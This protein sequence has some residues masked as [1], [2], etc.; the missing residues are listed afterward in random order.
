MTQNPATVVTLIID[1]VGIPTLEYLLDN[2]SG[3]IKFPNLEALGLGNLLDARFHSRVAPSSVADFAHTIN[4]TST[5][6]DSVIGHREIVGVM[7]FRE[8]SLFYDGFP[9]EYIT[10]LERRIGR[11]TIFNMRAGGEDAIDINREEHETHPDHPIIVYASMCDPLIQLAAHEGFVNPK[12]LRKMG[13]IA[14]ELALERG[15]KITRAITRPY[16]LTER[17][18]IKRTANRYDRVIN[19]DNPTLIDV[20]RDA[21]IWTASVGKPAELVNTAWDG[22]TKL[23]K[24]KYLDPALDLRFVHPEG[25]DIN[26]YTIQGTINELRAAKTIYRPNGTFIFA[27]CV[28]TDSLWGHKRKV[29]S[30]LK[31]VQE[32]DRCLPLILEEMRE[33]DILIVTADHGMEHRDDYGYHSKETV[34]LLAYRVGGGAERFTLVNP[35]TFA[36]VGNIVAQAFGIE[37]KF[38]EIL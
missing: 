5:S 33:G 24:I 31:A 9:P 23:T 11:T 16:V 19:L 27:N 1:A 25:N 4:Q 37:E 20:C 21:G 32:V 30:S 12:H 18:K 28:D 3:D 26:P 14:F 34:P 38:L 10:E 17:G 6:A 2:Y 36:S 8:Y 35:N 22:K 29:E 13:D 7:D 15:I